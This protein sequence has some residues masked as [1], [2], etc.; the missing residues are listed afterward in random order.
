MQGRAATLLR[1]RLHFGFLSSYKI[2]L[3]DSPWNFL[4]I[5]VSSALKDS[6]KFTFK[7]KKRS[8]GSSF[9]APDC[10]ASYF[11]KCPE[12]ETAWWCF[13]CYFKSLQSCLTLCDPTDCSPPDA[14]VHGIL[15]AILLWIAIPFSRGSSRPWDRIHVSYVFWIGR[16]AIT[17]TTWESPW[18][19]ETS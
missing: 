19:F 13:L 11:D 5:F 2:V 6:K 3:H 12:V 1:L 14:S 18:C 10:A 7:K 9:L 4:W 17:T 16:Q 15:Q 8:L